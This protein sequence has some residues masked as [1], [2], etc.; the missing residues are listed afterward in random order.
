MT[1]ITKRISGAIASLGA[2]RVLTRDATSDIP[3]VFSNDTWGG[4][5]GGAWGLSWFSASPLIPG[6]D[7]KP[8]LFTTSR[9]G[10]APSA[11]ITK[12]VALD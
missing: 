6:L 4:A 7:Q 8:S 11:N 3:P 5:W 9:I 12:R 10:S 2:K 1:T